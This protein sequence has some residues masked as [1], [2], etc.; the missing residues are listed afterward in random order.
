MCDKY[1]KI[2]SAKNDLV[3]KLIGLREK[4]IRD[5]NNEF[6]VEGKNL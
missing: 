3:K 5:I 1:K 6:V 2:F 4:K